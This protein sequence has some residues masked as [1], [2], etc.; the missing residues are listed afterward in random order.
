MMLSV[1]LAGL[2]ASASPALGANADAGLA[3]AAL[4]V[5]EQRYVKAVQP[6]TLL[7]A[8]VDSLRKTTH[9]DLPEIPDGTLGAQAEGVFRQDFARAAQADTANDGTLAYQTTRD[10]LASLHDTHTFYL[11]PAQ[12]KEWQD[13]YAGKPGYAGV[14]S[15]LAS[16][17]DSAGTILMVYVA[18]VF[19]RSPAAVAGLQRFDQIVQVDGTP[20][21][22]AVTPLDVA[23]I[24]RGPIGSTVTLTLRRKGRDVMLT[25]TRQAIEAPVLSTEMVRPGIAYL[26]LFQFTTGAADQFRSAVRSL[27]AQGSLRGVILDL[28]ENGGGLYSEMQGVA[29]TLL[30]T[31]TLLAHA[32]SHEGPSQFVATG[33][34]LLAQIPLVVLTDGNTAS[35][36]EVLSLALHD[37]HRATLIGEK[38]QGA[39]GETITLLL[40]AGGMGVTIAEVN[41]PQ[42]EQVEGVGIGPDQVVSL[43]VQDVSDGADPQLD[44]ALKAVGAGN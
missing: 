26:H 24:V 42:Y 32:V 17:K 5:L 4:H 25:A 19:P 27:E 14:G 13:R 41:G 30:P 7:N 43:T 44:A 39:L 8:A 34:P 29:G 22:P 33:T 11:D 36:G 16:I 6:V 35:N 9:E 12:F 2:L 20:I 40:P 38:T 21:A 28:R 23:R 10:M 15:L 3:I 37:A 1:V 18:A 31:G